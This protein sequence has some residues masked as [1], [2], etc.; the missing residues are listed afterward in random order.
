V[1]YGGDNGKPW[2]GALF[3]RARRTRLGD[4]GNL[5]QADGNSFP[6]FILGWTIGTNCPCRNFISGDN[7]IMT[8]TVEAIYDHGKLLLPAPLSLPEKS[9]VRV[10]IESDAEREAWLKLSEENLLKTW[11]HPD[12]DVFNELLAK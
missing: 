7:A 9:R 1:K 8:M 3:H 5:M 10:T 4:D 11:N 12:D 2:R 6:V